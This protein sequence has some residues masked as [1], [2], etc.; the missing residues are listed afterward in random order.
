MTGRGD[1]RIMRPSTNPAVTIG[2]TLSTPSPTIT[3]SSTLTLTLTARIL[4]IPHPALPI[5]LTAYQNPFA[6]IPTNPSYTAMQCIAPKE[7][8]AKRIA[9]NP[10][11]QPRAHRGMFGKRV[12][13]KEWMEWMWLSKRA[14]EE[15]EEEGMEE[16]DEGNKLGRL[17]LVELERGEEPDLLAL[18]IESGE[19]D[20]EVV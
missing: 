7:S 14:E 13:L 10:Y 9:I 16:E 1:G 3:P 15:E 6:R 8:E 12:N 11:A 17:S 5:T 19:V 20:F 18:V 4:T 2:L